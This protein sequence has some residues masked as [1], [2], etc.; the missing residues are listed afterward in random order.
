MRRRALLAGILLSPALGHAQ[1]QTSDR[2]HR[3]GAL[4]TS[5]RSLHHIRTVM[6]PELARHGFVEGRNLVL[7]ARVGTVAQLPELA[8]ELVRLRVDAV[9]TVGNAPTAAA[10]EATSSIPIVMSA[11]DPVE[12]GLVKSLARPETNATGVVM[13]GSQLDA[14]RVQLLQQALPDANSLAMLTPPSALNLNA[15]KQALREKAE[16]AGIKL[17]F[18]DAPT[19]ET[20]ADAFQSVRASGARAL[21]VGSDPQFA[22]DADRLARLAV[23]TGLPTICQWREMAQQGCLLSYGPSLPGLFR[24]HGEL[25][26]RIFKGGVP[27]EMPIEGPT[28]FEFIINLRTAK[29][30]G[31]VIEPAILAVADEVIE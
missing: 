29:A 27:G 8:R 10:R 26:A 2:V 18:F 30:L 13:L 21:I 19:P 25:V 16:S 23:E 12:L 14:K 20:Y 9:V 1:A 3:L 31:I 17:T 7:D 5:E 15:R 24:R 11:A 22:R 28:Q 4:L 6:L